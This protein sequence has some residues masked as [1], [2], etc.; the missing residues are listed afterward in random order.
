MLFRSNVNVGNIALNATK[1]G[2]V[3]STGNLTVGRLDLNGGY[4]TIDPLYGQKASIVAIGQLGRSTDILTNDVNY[5]GTLRGHISV[6]QNAIGVI[7]I[8]DIAADAA[9]NIEAQSAISQV[10]ELFAPYLDSKTG[11]LSK[12]NVGAIGYVAKA[13]T[14]ASGSSL[15]I[16]GYEKQV[17]DFLPQDSTPTEPGETPTYNQLVGVYEHG[18]LAVNIA[19]V[20]AAT[21]DGKSVA[22][23][24]MDT[25]SGAAYF[26]ST[27][28]I[29]LVGT[30]ANK[31]LQLFSDNDATTDGSK[32]GV[33]ILS[34]DGNKTVRVETLSGLW[35][36]DLTVGEEASKVAINPQNDLVVEK[37]TAA[38]YPVQDFIKAN[39]G[40]FTSGSWI[41]NATQLSAHGQEA[42]T[43]ARLGVYA[44]AVQTG[45][46]SAQSTTD[47]ISGRFGMGAGNSAVTFADN[48]QGAGL[49]VTPIYQS[50]DSDGFE[51][52]GQEYGAD[53]TL[54][55]VALGADYSLGNGLRVGVAFNV[56]SGDAD[57][58]GIANL[59]KNDFNYY[60]GAL[61]AGYS[62]GQF[63]VIGDVS[64]TVVDNDVEGNIG[65]LHNDTFKIQSS[66]D[67]KAL[68]VGVTAK[69]ALDVNG[70]T[71]TPHA[72]LR[73]TSL[74]LENYMV[75]D[76]GNNIAESE[77]DKVNIFS[78]PVGVTF[79]KTFTSG[80]WNIKPALDL[81]VTGN[82]GD[83]EIDNATAFAGSPD[84]VYIDNLKTEVIDN[85]TYG[86]GLGLSAQNGN[87]SLGIG[88]N[89]TGSS[90]T[91][92]Y[93]IGANARFVF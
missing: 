34:D 87:L 13:I 28:K 11:S 6:E 57:G 35:A 78:I 85:F 7:G 71:L 74:D 67:T 41:D 55:G 31:E 2:L 18:V 66:F 21:H 54:Y 20:T 44:G 26:D 32:S 16:S 83:D 61:Y 60:G 29:V 64:Y 24:H 69:Y 30:T 47:A 53:V 73:Y 8:T 80:S 86:V 25:N 68:S 72:G 48:G 77:F 19:N 89:Y 12:D 5:A 52:Q 33:L 23:I 3:G 36:A 27:S 40:K 17:K 37:W 51:A 58:Q 50:Q 38:S 56:G 4:L 91:N 1:D 43:A 75:V 76:D 63:S 84:D 93:G 42:E 79:D 15:S 65:A 70:F 9:N 49:W 88:V 59:V 14:L 22:A 90:N 45:L 82:F 92:S 62:V 39:L 81:T 46:L 10:Q